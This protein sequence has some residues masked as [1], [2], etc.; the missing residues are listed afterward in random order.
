[1]SFDV[2]GF[3]AAGIDL[4]AVIT[5]TTSNGEGYTDQARLVAAFLFNFGAWLDLRSRGPTI[6]IGTD[7]SNNIQRD[8]F[9]GLTRSA[10]F[11]ETAGGSANWS[12]ALRVNLL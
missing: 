11:A 5:L 6:F 10:D 2:T 3:V 7:P 1:M 8:G 12:N 4:D 9:S